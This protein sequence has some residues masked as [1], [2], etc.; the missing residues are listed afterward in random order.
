[1]VFAWSGD[2][3]DEELAVLVVDVLHRGLQQVGRKL[4][5]LVLDLP[6]CEG[7]RRAGHRRCAAAVGAPA[8]RSLVRVAVEHLHVVH[9]DAERVGDDL[10]ERGLLTLPVGRG[11]DGHVDLAR[12]VE[13]HDCALPEAALEADGPGDLGRAEAADL[14]VR[15]DADADVLAL[16]PQA[17]LLLAKVVVADPL[18]SHVEGRGEVA[19]V[20]GQPGRHVVAVL[21][22]RYQVLA[23]D[24]DR[25]HVQRVGELVDHPLDQ[26][27]GLGSPRRPCRR[28]PA[29]RC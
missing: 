4:G 12:R 20:V 23:A 7:Q 3:A 25:V 27:Y 14:G 17:L 24:L 18:G 29:R 1:M 26:E 22:C 19:A 16:A 5:G 15:R 28:R 10:R 8:H 11:A 2:P 6:R 13:P 21:E 9:F